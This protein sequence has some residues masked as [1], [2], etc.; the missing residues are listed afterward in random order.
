MKGVYPGGKAGILI[1]YSRVKTDQPQSVSHPPYA[2]FCP[3]CSQLSKV[4][5]GVKHQGKI[6]YC[7]KKR[8]Q[9]HTTFYSI[10]LIVLLLLLQ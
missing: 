5:Y 8:D 3:L 2:R 7:N 1:S 10:L 9:F 6:S 4:N